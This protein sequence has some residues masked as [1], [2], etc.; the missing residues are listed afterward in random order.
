MGSLQQT[1]EKLRETGAIY[2]E[3]IK[4]LKVDEL[5]VLSEEIQYWCIYGNGKAEKL[6]KKHKGMK[7]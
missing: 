2:L 1:V 5:E 7:F 6:G 3:D 4:T